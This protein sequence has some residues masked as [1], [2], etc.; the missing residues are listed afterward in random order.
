MNRT[1][2][3]I[4]LLYLVVFGLA[5][6]VGYRFLTPHRETVDPSAK[7]L[8]VTPAGKLADDEMTTIKIFEE[9]SKSVV[10]VQSL[11]YQ[12]NPFNLNVQKIARGTGT[13]FVWDE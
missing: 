6:F 5:A 13:G 9:A 2:S 4:L 7:P 3:S 12:Q 1:S 11:A 10:N 8:A